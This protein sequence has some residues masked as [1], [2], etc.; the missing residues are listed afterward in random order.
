MR[1][2]LAKPTARGCGATD[3]RKRCTTSSSL[4]SLLGRP[5]WW[6]DGHFDRE[7]DSCWLVGGTVNDPFEKVTA[8]FAEQQRSGGFPGGQ[9]V[10][11]R[12]GQVVCAVSVGLARGYRDE[13][14]AVAVAPCT[15]FQVMSA[16]KPFVAFAIALLD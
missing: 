3:G 8:L 5:S 9:L 6:R 14:P 12:D 15:R 11:M 4:A 16:S 2:V 13:E 10:V 1:R 7:P